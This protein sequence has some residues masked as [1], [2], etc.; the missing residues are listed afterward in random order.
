MQL[1]NN[2]NQVNPDYVG[3]FIETSAHTLNLLGTINAGRGGMWLIDPTNVTISTSPSTGGSLATAQASTTT[4]NFN[5]TQIET[6]INAGTSVTILVSGTITQSNALTFNVTAANTTPTLTLDNTSGSKQSITLIAMTDNS[7]GAGSGVSVRAISSG[8]AIAVN[9]AIN[10]KGSI[11]LDNTFG[12]TG[13]GCTP[14]SGFITASNVTTLATTAAAGINVTSALTTS[15]LITLNGVSTGATA[16]NA[17]VV[18]SAAIAGAG[19][20]TITA[21]TGG[22]NGG[23]FLNTGTSS[24]VSSAGNIS[25]NATALGATNIGFNGS[26]IATAITATLGSVSI[27]GRAVGGASVTQSGL[28]TARSIIIDGVASGNPTTNVTLGAMTISTGGSNISVTATSGTAGGNTG[29][30]QAGNITGVSGS[31]ISFTSNNKIDQNGA[32]VLAA[33]GSAN[34]ANITYD[35]TTG[36]RLSTIAGGTLTIAANASSSAINYT[37]ISAGANIDPGLIGTTLIVLPGTITLDNTFGASSGA[38]V[39][40]F[41]TPSNATDQATASIGVTIDNA[42][43]ASGNIAVNGV[44]SGNGVAGI[45]YSVGITSTAGNVTL[46]GG[47]TNGLGVYNLTAS[48][49]TANNITINGLTSLAPNWATYIGTLTINTAATGGNI[50]VTGNVINTPGGAGGI[51][52]SGAITTRSGSNISFTSNN[53]INQIGAIVLAA[54]TSANVANI[55]YDTTTGT[56]VST[57]VG[58]NLSIAANTSSSAI[59]YTM[60]SAGANIDPGSI[61]TSS[62]VL[63]GAITIDNT[64]GSDSGARASGYIT[65]SVANRLVNLASA[66]AG[67]S[68]DAAIFASGNITINGA[69]NTNRGIDASVNIT[70]TNGNVLMNG[71]TVETIGVYVVAANVVTANNITIN[72][73]ATSAPGWVTQIGGLTINSTSVGGSII[74]TGNVINTPGAAGGV[75]QIGTITGASG[76]N[77][78]FTSNNDISQNGQINLAANTSGTAANIT[79]DTTTG[80]RVSTI[81]GS[82]LTIATNTSSS[83]INYTMRS[84]GANIDPGLIGTSSI[85]LPGA[86]TIDNTFGSDSGARSSGYI[87]ASVANRLVNLA[88]ASAGVSLDAAIFASGNITINGASNTNRGIDAS[89]NITSTNGNVLMNGATVETIGVYVVAANM[90]TAN[91]ITINGTATSAPGWVTQ[92]GGLTINSTSVG[93][94]IIVTGNVINTPGAAGGVYQIGTITGASGSNISF[95]SNNDINQGGA[96]NLAANTSGTASS[97]TY[98]TTSGVR[99]SSIDT[100]ALSIAAGSNSSINYSVLSSGSNITIG[101]TVVVPGSITLDNTYGCAASTPA[102][103]P[104]TGYINNNLANWT[105]LAVAGTGI[106]VGSGATMSGTAVTINAVNSNVNSTFQFFSPI[107]ATT[108]DITIDALGTSGWVV[109]NGQSGVGWFNGSLTANNGAI[110]INASATTS[111][112]GVFLHGGT[113]MGRLSARAISVESFSSSGTYAA[114]LAEL[115]IAA[116]GTNINITGRVGTTS[117]TG[118]YQDG[119]IVSSAAGSNISFITNGKINQLGAISLVSNTTSTAVSITYNT[120]SGGR[121]SSV[122]AGALTIAAGTNNSPINYI[123]KTAGSAINPGTIGTSLLELPGYILLDNTYGCTASTPACTPTTNFINTT[124]ANLST[125][126]TTAVGV[127]VNAAIHATGNIV[128]NGVASANDGINY[129]VAIVSRRGDVSFNGGTT[130]LRA[131]HNST[132]SII[133]ANNITII[134][135]STTAPSWVTQIG[136]LTINSTSVGG[137]IAV[138]GNVIATPGAAGGIYQTGEIRGASGSSITFTSNNNISQS[139]AIILAANISGIAANITYDITA[140]N[141]TSSIVGGALTIPAG[142]TSAINYIIKTAGSAINPA[143]I[144]TSLLYCQDMYC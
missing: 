129:S 67:V 139:G 144:G 39:S 111:G 54:N 41:V 43:F 143:A 28:I 53:D 87:T 57:I 16:G 98:N 34:V 75:Y 81:F 36:T 83:A 128:V 24:I 37:A 33:N 126:A 18:T 80:T 44:S 1:L 113:T 4:S 109:T 140:G 12:C 55:T 25:I 142:S 137:N 50:T 14:Q 134:G 26:T 123:I 31:S 59:N 21:V 122:V 131:I 9:G 8:G 107:T 127:T 6:A 105:S 85:V 10:V 77:I 93:G 101:G 125:L 89:V 106:S 79:Y 13:T 68:L 65:A 23:V 69:S 132:A 138:T 78:S 61:G 40:G 7:A 88:S 22:T 135:T 141:R 47:A 108:G 48:T 46:N 17:A 3:G 63:P 95:I 49:I 27:T 130:T 19:G 91:N 20:V 60:Q 42:I 11:T 119:P 32:L 110:R 74:V 136:A 115:R 76:S 30:S 64:F 103:T 70:S 29:I 58:G 86:I 84:A 38:R 15:G 124:T 102:C 56:R 35:T 52:Q 5:T 92:I 114:Y 62:I 71:A 66:S 73:T 121:D 82:T 94:S 99:T 118:I 45:S 72:G 51:Y 2:Q 90:V 104:A 117:T 96:I 120:T 112:I 97:I 100:G 133:T 116:G